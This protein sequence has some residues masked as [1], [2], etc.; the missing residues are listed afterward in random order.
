MVGNPEAPPPLLAQCHAVLGLLTRFVSAAQD[1]AEHAPRGKW[2][3]CATGHHVR[4][5]DALCPRRV[6]WC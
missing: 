6:S 2:P 4:V 5:P 1:E 3:G